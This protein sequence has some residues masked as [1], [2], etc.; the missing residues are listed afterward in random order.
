MS[1]FVNTKDVIGNQ[2]TLDSILNQ[3]IT[4]FA[5]EDVTGIAG[6]TFTACRDLRSVSIPN[7]TF[8]KN[9]AFQNCYQ[10]SDYYAPKM[11][12]SEAYGLQS[13][14]INTIKF[15][16]PPT[17]N[18]S[19][20]GSR[21]TNYFTAYVIDY[22]PG[23]KVTTLNGEAFRYL[24]NCF[25]LILRLP[26]VIALGTATSFCQWSPIHEGYGWIYV[27]DN[28]V[29]TVKTTTGYL[30]YAN[31]IVGISQYPKAITGDTITDTWEQI[32]AAE[33]DGTYSTKYS[34]GD[35]KFLTI[36]NQLVLMEIVA[37]DRDLLSDDSGRTAKI[38]WMTRGCHQ[39]SQ[40][41][42]HSNSTLGG[43]PQSEIKQHIIERYLE[44]MDATVKSHIKQ[45]RKYSRYYT[46][47]GVE[48]KNLPSD[49]YIWIPSWRE[50]AGNTNSAGETKGVTYTDYY[51]TQASR[52]K[53][54]NACT[55][56]SSYQ[57]YNYMTRTITSATKYATFTATAG[58]ENRAMKDNL[59]VVFGFCT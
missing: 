2:N 1:E 32:F 19:G 8:L 35:T 52:K 47:D 40:Y 41:N 11:Y 7:V 34:V 57:A 49:D 28:L 10:L 30:T 4:D 51:S 29:D 48:T 50:M 14:D 27:P 6:Y 44:P 39:Y 24:F 13:V 25:H 9:Y 15:A 37:F 38:T 43:W 5:D 23:D 31:Q 42:R 26:S 55:A 17:N 45:V 20:L 21:F 12:G 22:T 46:P 18:N 58:Q 56:S 16:T 3:T 54:P 53:Y 59:A 33:E 36:R